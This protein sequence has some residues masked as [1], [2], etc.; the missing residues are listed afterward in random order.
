MSKKRYFMKKII[1]T[2]L[3]LIVI[4]AMIFNIIIDVSTSYAATTYKQEKKQGID[5]FPDSYKTY[6][7]ELQ[8]LHSNW[9]FTAFNTGMTWKDF[10]SKET[11]SHL[12]N[13][14]H[15]SSDAL[16]KD[17]C[18]QVA[19]GYAC[20]SQAILEYYADPRN[21]LTESSV[22]QFLEMTYNSSVHTKAGVDSILKGSF[23][24]KTVTISGSNIETSA[25]AKISGE[26]ILA[27]PGIKIQEIAENLKL[28]NYS[29]TD[30]AKK[31]VQ[32]SVKSM[33][34]YT[35]KDN[36]NDKT[37]TI[38]VLGDVN[39]DGEVKSTDYMRIKSY[40]MD[41]AKM[42][43][44]EKLAADINEDG[45]I[46]STDYMRIKSYI[47]DSN[48]ITVKQTGEGSQTMSYS[49]IIMKAAE[50]SG[51]SPYSI[52]IKIFQEVGRQGSSSVT[53][54]Y[55]GYEGYYNFF[56]YGAY[57]SGNAIANGLKYA[58][59]KGWSNQYIS[60][61]E[62]AKLMADSYVGVGQ[63]TAY[64][65]KFDVV[66]EG[67]NGV[68]SHQYMT[69]I[70]DPASQATTLYNTYA[71][72]NMLNVA[73]NFVIPVFNDMPSRCGL[74]GQIDSNLDTS[75]YINGTGVNLR[76]NPT[77]SASS[78]GT[79]TLNEVVTVENFNVGNSDGYDWAKIKRGNGTTGYVANKYLTK[80]K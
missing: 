15:K 45:Q 57:D 36:L 53:G 40:I 13:T 74:P 71:K 11:S 62:G 32:N 35:L 37:Y 18:N 43:D 7:K 19:S 5:A 59:D 39:G 75:Y 76:N 20:A 67:R 14:V 52:A 47:M 6:L 80:C 41:N 33:T 4:L 46:K 49:E 42:N 27:T 34:G 29:A 60:I 26:Y 72:N 9:T 44:N 64:L 12:K 50:E 68:C 70:Q 73:L 56:N 10:I 54:T 31:T 25:K 55:Q 1:S 2:Q 48:P 58:K 61:V 22:F 78:I 66:D 21:F 8:N 51:I 79:L 77:T 28:T 24:D 63:N 30:A 69:N 38:I 65:Y 16:W 3:L 17:S 23:M